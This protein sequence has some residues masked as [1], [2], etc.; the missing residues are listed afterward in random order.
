MRNLA[1]IIAALAIAAPSMGVG[2]AFAQ[3]KTT[4]PET[5]TAKVENWTIE[6]W[7]TAKAEW[8]KDEAKWANCQQQSTDRKLAG[9]ES[10]S[11]LY[12]CMTK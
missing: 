2:L 5:T 8:A 3:T 4:G 7:N 12:T 10:W 1:F 9:R 6:Q 11:F